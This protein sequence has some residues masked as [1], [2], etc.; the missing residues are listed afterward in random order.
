MNETQSYI[1]DIINLVPDQSICFIQAP[2]L[3]SAEFQNLMTPSSFPY[4]Q[5]LILSPINKG[6]LINLIV[7]ECIE[8]NFQSLEIRLDGELLFEGYD[9]MEYGLISKKV[10]LTNKFRDNYINRDMCAVSNDW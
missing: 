7:N 4:Y 6:L 1:I 8:D 2:S 5:Q 3:E 10:N 9:G